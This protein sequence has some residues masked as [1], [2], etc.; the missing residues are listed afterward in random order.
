MLKSSVCYLVVF[1]GLY[2]ENPCLQRQASCIMDI[3]FFIIFGPSCVPILWDQDTIK[4]SL[5]P[6]VFCLFRN[7]PAYCPA[8]RTALLITALLAQHLAARPSDA[9]RRPGKKNKT[10][11]VRTRRSRRLRCY[12]IM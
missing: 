3:F 8:S 6:S 10:E 4:I 11:A 1:F 7:P 5:C 9:L 2:R 12:L